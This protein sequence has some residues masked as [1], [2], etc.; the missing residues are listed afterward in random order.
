MFDLF[1]AIEQAT[2]EWKLAHTVEPKEEYP[3]NCQTEGKPCQRWCGAIPCEA[4]SYWDEKRKDR[5]YEFKQIE[6]EDH[7]RVWGDW[8]P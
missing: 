7:E 8:K 3:F 6:A 2:R 5:Y 4:T 1:K